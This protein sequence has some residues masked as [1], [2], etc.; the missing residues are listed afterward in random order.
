MMKSKDKSPKPSVEFIRIFFPSSAEEIIAVRIAGILAS[1]F[2]EQ[3]TR[4]RPDTRLKEVF[5]WAGADSL[6]AVN[7]IMELEEFSGLEIED[8][9]ASDFEKWTFR[10]L[11]EYATRRNRDA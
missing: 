3:V 7:F 8:D 2:G 10:E 5:G 4:L 1:V 11:V 9:F 6:D